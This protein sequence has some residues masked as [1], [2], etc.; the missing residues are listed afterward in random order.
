MFAFGF[1]LNIL[2]IISQ[3]ALVRDEIMA[4]SRY[5]TKGRRKHGMMEM[6]TLLDGIAP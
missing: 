3:L 6:L 1:H 4:T 2:F 5:A